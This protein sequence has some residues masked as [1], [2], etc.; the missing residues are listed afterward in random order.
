ML[1]ICY[2][3]GVVYLRSSFIF[4]LLRKNSTFVNFFDNKI[5]KMNPERCFYSMLYIRQLRS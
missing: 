5:L 1:Q 2:A 3:T 4:I